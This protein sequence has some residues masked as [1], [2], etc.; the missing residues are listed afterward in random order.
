MVRLQNPVL[1]KELKLR[2]RSFKSFSA[3]IFYLLTLLV[4]TVG[5]FLVVTDFKG[6]GFIGPEMN[7]VLFTMLTFVQLSVVLFMTP[8]LTAGAISTE[9]EKQTLN[10]LL[11]TSQTSWQIIF[12]KLTSSISYLLLLLLAGMPISSVVFLFGGISPSDFV[13]TYAY[14]IVILIALASI[15]ILMSTLI[16][17]TIVAMITTYGIMLFLTVMTAFFVFVTLSVQTGFDGS[18]LGGQKPFSYF[19]MAINPLIHMASVI[20]PEVSESA[21]TVTSM[22]LPLWVTHISFYVIITVLCLWIATKNI[23]VNMK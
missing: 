17:K 9:R 11:T 8:G 19:F 14:M 1:K 2:F 6:K 18:E 21:L 15:G 13:L 3:I 16:R 4:F 22:D 7:V 20:Y 5:F 23:R 10:I 12:G